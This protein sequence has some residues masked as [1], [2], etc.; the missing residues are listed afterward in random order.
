MALKLEVRR[1]ILSPAAL[2]YMLNPL[3]VEHAQTRLPIVIWDDRVR[4]TVIRWRW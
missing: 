4:F 2:G 3:Y 1:K